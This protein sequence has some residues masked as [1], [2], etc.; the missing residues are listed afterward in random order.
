[1]T[2]ATAVAT[3]SRNGVS[4]SISDHPSSSA[5]RHHRRRRGSGSAGRAPAR[6][7][8]AGGGTRG[9]RPPGARRRCRRRRPRR[10]RRPSPRRRTTRRARGRPAAARHGLRLAGQDRLVHPQRRRCAASAPV[11][12]HLVAGA[13]QRPGRPAPP[14]AIATWHR[15]RRRA[16]PSRAGATSAASRSRLALGP[17]LL[18]DADPGVQDQDPQEHRVAPVAEDQRDD[19]EEQQRHVE[20]GQQVGPQDAGP[21]AAGGGALDSPRAARRR[22]ASAWVRPSSAAA[23]GRPSRAVGGRAQV[24]QGLRD[25]RR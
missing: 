10:R 13:H 15:A 9:P 6:A 24:G 3:A 17:G 21:R 16:P 8:S 5:Q 23:E 25:G 7:A 20:D 19:A 18:H 12:H 22:W 11:G 4:C 2:P 14:A 1:M